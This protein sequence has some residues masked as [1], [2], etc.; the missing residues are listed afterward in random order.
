MIQHQID[1][2]PWH[3]TLPR[4]SICGE[5]HQL[6]VFRVFIRFSLMQSSSRDNFYCGTKRCLYESVL[7]SFK[8]KIKG[9][10]MA[11]LLVT[12]ACCLQALQLQIA[13]CIYPTIRDV[14]SIAQSSRP[15]HT[16]GKTWCGTSLCCSAQHGSQSPLCAMIC[17]V[18]LPQGY[19][20][21]GFVELHSDLLLLP[22]L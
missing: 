10:L 14:G 11:S 19:C 5:V 18:G 21:Y 6:A 17:Q 7:P 16:C 13:S 22:V 12:S 3:D 1:L 9:V 4:I 15:S 20:F 2:W 8:I